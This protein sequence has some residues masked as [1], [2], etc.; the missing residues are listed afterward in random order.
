MNVTVSLPGQADGLIFMGPYSSSGYTGPGPRIY[1]KQ[2]NLVW[3]GYGVLPGNAHNV[4]VCQ[5]NGSSHLCMILGSDQAGYAAGVG[6]ILDSNYRIVQTVQTGR[7]A[8]PVCTCF[9]P[10]TCDFADRFRSTNTNSILSTMEPMP[11]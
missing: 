9:A 1:D 3:D 10:T 8:M 6:M 2:G 5:Y 11:S 4:H 7:N